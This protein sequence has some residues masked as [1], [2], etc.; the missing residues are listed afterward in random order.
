M[1]DEKFSDESE[2]E[3]SYRFRQIHETIL[4]YL[5][6]AWT[7]FIESG[8]IRKLICGLHK[9]NDFKFRKY[10]RRDEILMK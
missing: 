6:H 4:R 7:D 2:E 8:L 9:K 5:C 3:T 10:C 1:F